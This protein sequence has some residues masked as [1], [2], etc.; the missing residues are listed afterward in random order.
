MSARFW[1]GGEDA[2]VMKMGPTTEPKSACRA[3]GLRAP[4]VRAGERQRT[5]IPHPVRCVSVV[6]WGGGG[7][8]RGRSR[9]KS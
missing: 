1:S 7:T 6:D 5:Q 4:E 8:H 3:E 2:R 9:R